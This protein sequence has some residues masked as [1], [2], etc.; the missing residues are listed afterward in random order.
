MGRSSSLL[1]AIL[2]IV[3]VVMIAVRVNH[4]GQPQRSQMPD[5][6]RQK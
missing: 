6:F 1:M 2:V 5:F 4:R 3:F